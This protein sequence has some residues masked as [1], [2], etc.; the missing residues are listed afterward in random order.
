MAGAQ[1]RI[2]TYAGGGPDDVAAIAA[3]IGVPTAVARDASGNTFVASQSHR[4]FKIDAAG[5]LTV[6]AGIGVGGFGGDGGPARDAT[7]FA[8]TGIAVD[9]GGN[10]FICDWGNARIRRVDAIT[11]DITTIAGGGSDVGD[12]GP[13]A[14]AALAGPNGVAVDSAGLVYIA[15]TGANHIRKI[16][17]SGNIT[18]VAAG[19]LTFPMA[20]A[21][22]AAG[23][24][25]VA[26]TGGNRVQ[27]VDASGVSTVTTAS[28]PSGVAV[29]GGIL[30][31]AEQAG[32]RVVQVAAGTTT[33]IAGTGVPGFSGDGGPAIAARLSSNILGIAANDS[34]DVFIADSFNR[35][36]R[37]LDGASGNIDTVA[38]N[39]QF[40]FSGDGVP[41]TKASLTVTGLAVDAAGNVLF[42][43]AGRIRRV[44]A[45]SGVIDTL[46]GSEGIALEGF[47]I[48]ADG[49]GGWL[50]ADFAGHQVR[51][52]DGS[53]T[54]T[55]VA[56]TG[57]AGY[58]GDGFAA[59]A[60]RLNGPMAVGVDAVGNIYI[61]DTFNH[62]VRKIDS[63]GTI[64]TV[65]GNG[66]TG[67]GGGSPLGDGGL[68]TSARVWN[69][70]GVALRA[71][72]LY[73]AEQFGHRV[74][75]VDLSGT[76]TTFAG[77]G[78]GGDGGPASSASLGRPT[79]LAFDAPG[80]LYITETE[81]NV[82]RV[83]RVD[84]S[85]TIETIA[86]TG[87]SGFSGDGGPATLATFAQLS[88][89]G[90]AVDSTGNVLL[91]DR[92]NNRIRRVTNN[93][94][95]AD[96]G[97][98]VIATP[99][100]AFTL[101]GAG[102]SD[103]DGD[104]L[105]YEWTDQFGSFV[106]SSPDVTLTRG[107]GTYTFTLKVSDGFT[108]D[109]DTLVV[110]MNPVVLVSTRG[111]G[112]GAVASDDG[113]I[114]CASF[115]GGDCAEGYAAG[116]QVTLTAT[117]QQWSVFGGWD[118]DGPCAAFTTDVCVFTVP[119]DPLVFVAATFDPQKFTLTVTNAGGGTVTSNPVG[120][121]N[122]GTTCSALLPATT[123][124]ALTAT[125]QAGY[126]FDGWS[127]ACTG[128]GPCSVAMTTHVSVTAMFSE[129]TLA[130]LAV[131]PASA[132]IGVGQTQPFTATGHFT[133][134]PDR[135]VSPVSALEGGDGF[136]CA[137]LVNGTVKCWGAFAGLVP[138]SPVPVTI[139]GLSEVVSL[140]AGTSQACAVLANGS[141][142]CW[143]FGY[144][145]NGPLTTST[146]PV[147]VS[148]ITS[149]TAVVV[150]ASTRHACALLADGSIRCWGQGGLLG[151]GTTDEAL[152]PVAVSGITNAVAI[153]SEGG[154][155]TCALLANREIRC[156]GESPL[157]QLG[158]GSAAG[159]IATVPVTVSGIADATAVAAGS[160]H[161]CA[162]VGGGA[163]KC[164][165]GNF[166]GQIGT[167]MIGGGWNTPVPVIGI[168]NAVAIAAGDFHTCALL[169]D[170][171]ARCWGAE[172]A[173]GSPAPSGTPIVIAGV[174]NATALGTGD[175][176]SCAMLATGSVK[177][178]GL[179]VSGQL[180]DGN[181]V[182]SPN[183]VA[184]VGVATGLSLAW[185]SSDP[186]AHIDA[187]GRAIGVSPS[188]VTIGAAMSGASATATLL[189]NGNTPSGSNVSVTP[190]DAATGA[191]P[192]TLTF[193]S[194]TQ[195]GMT[196]VTMSSGGPAPPAGF[197]LGTPPVYYELTTTAVFAGS[198]TV[199]IDYTG[200][201]FA[202]PPSLYHLENGVMVDR[203][204]SVDALNE[205]V[206]GSVTSL[207][208]FALFQDAAAPEI[209]E[210]RPDQ[211]VLWPPNHR[212]VGVKFS[213]DAGD[214]SGVAPSCRIVQVTSSEPVSGQGDGDAS[215]DWL[216][217]GDLTAQLRAERSGGGSG[218]VYTVTVRCTD[219]AGNPA[220]ATASVQVPHD[221]RR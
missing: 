109:T 72:N 197:Q 162:I 187:H 20:V 174:S 163:V 186:A 164:W 143:G 158:D 195:P 203:T 132:T 81:V 71:G 183:P 220:T 94:P 74:R 157:G 116:T 138:S 42:P 32:A 156:W 175:A 52:I 18:T 199:C 122:C 127:G 169:S 129:I 107:A 217:T 125:E 192:A 218:R 63:A 27:R 2:E 102:S 83:R 11:L 14:S 12:G 215:P 57:V 202:G 147:T 198:I 204:T 148:G 214:N 135:V 90:V 21:V 139:A 30:Y 201:V 29:A 28:S 45:A 200:I 41:A 176:H 194:V 133:F 184:V 191:A 80:N 93:A 212:M 95:V 36:V 172:F 168:T 149:A 79:S 110:S 117:P 146:T 88:P 182:A 141:V 62:R 58:S 126:R 119:S 89:W 165:G 104:A 15:E 211:P 5:H 130:Q 69:P 50:V 188:T 151:D 76:I 128:A 84:P 150:G 53:G 87:A 144:L 40:T 112:F 161:T 120:T 105:S 209:R 96:A 23:D 25:F 154:L 70:T 115:T 123:Q 73:I 92:F 180:G 13:A 85:G 177:C 210:V 66:T 100:V 113:G 91:G 189:V 8:P 61:A 216:I 37:R 166:F 4:V 190:I 56:G 142:K 68:A 124:I 39:G 171:S 48:A 167:G 213:V 59:T 173:S 22:D 207:S 44:T 140:G 208:P 221:R 3:A 60:A 114:A 103:P 78:T 86:G 106:A 99:G 46:P 16:D 51:R 67:L 111:D 75:M 136:T 108:S 134:G 19:D 205:I 55:T 47:G 31:V 26:D 137:L 152:T 101:S 33:T 97:A 54:V 38:G 155:H 206:C 10:V 9:A 82:S 35:R 49:A 159:T 1:H 185:T 131:S 17:A 153:S 181:T 178:W 34:G 77:G 6:F 24:I 65:A 196:S 193:S 145:G 170:G 98:D 160:S 7:L 64:T 219:A 118:V 121:I 179:G 43:D